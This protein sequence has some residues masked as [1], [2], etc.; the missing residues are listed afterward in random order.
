[1]TKFEIK[2]SAIVESH[3]NVG[4]FISAARMLSSLIRVS[5]TEKSRRDLITLAENL[6]LI[7]HAEFRI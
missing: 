2:Q 5:R 1:M 7:G 3:V 4:N 6:R